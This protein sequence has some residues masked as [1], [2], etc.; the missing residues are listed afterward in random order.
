MPSDT[1]YAGVASIFRSAYEA[2]E[3]PQIFEDGMQLR[4]FVHVA[5]VARAN[6]LT[7]DSAWTGAV[8][9]ASGEP[10]TVLDLAL[11]IQVG[12][13]SGIEPQITGQYRLGDVRHVVASPLLAFDALGFA[14]TTPFDE[15]AAAFSTAPLRAACAEAR[16]VAPTCG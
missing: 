16:E 1:P 5:D 14:A 15:G 13:G 7:L 3:P 8:N 11:A 10:H 6:L 2:G 4:D 12:L 9:V